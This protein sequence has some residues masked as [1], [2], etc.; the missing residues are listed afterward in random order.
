M[1]EDIKITWEQID[2]VREKTLA[3]MWDSKQALLVTGGNVEEAI[4]L[5]NNYNLSNL[6]IR[7]KLMTIEKRLNNLRRFNKV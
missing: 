5:I 6:E 3:G 2:Q 1:S 4:E 7:Y